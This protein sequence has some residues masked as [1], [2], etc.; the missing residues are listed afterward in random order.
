MFVGLEV[1]FMSSTW[2][3]LL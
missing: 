2:N 3:S 1:G